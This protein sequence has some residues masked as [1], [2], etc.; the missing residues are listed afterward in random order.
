[1]LSGQARAVPPV[2]AF[3]RWRRPPGKR[4]AQDALSGCPRPRQ[5][6]HP[7]G[8]HD[9]SHGVGDDVSRMLSGAFPGSAHL[10]VW[11]GQYWSVRAYRVVETPSEL[12]L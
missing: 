6:K 11:S 4:P 3:L 5:I 7:I 12:L 9:P 2:L 10:V 8:D 1:M